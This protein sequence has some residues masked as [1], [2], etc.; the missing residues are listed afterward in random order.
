MTESNFLLACSKSVDVQS[1]SVINITSPQYPKYYPRSVICYWKITT[2]DG[3]PLSVRRIWIDMQNTTACNSDYLQ[4]TS[5][6]TERICGTSR[7]PSTNVFNSGSV[8][9][10]FV[11]DERINGRGFLLQVFGKY[12]AGSVF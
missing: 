10:K 2:V 3:N 4:F 1:G 11:S 7:T 9:I 8:E 5:T 6:K 12:I